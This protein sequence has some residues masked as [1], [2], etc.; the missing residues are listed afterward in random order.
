MCVCVNDPSDQSVSRHSRPCQVQLKEKNLTEAVDELTEMEQLIVSIRQL[1]DDKSADN[2]RLH[3]HVAEL[4]AE[5]VQ[6]QNQVLEL[7]DIVECDKKALVDQKTHGSAAADD[8]AA[9]VLKL[10]STEAE[11]ASVRQSRDLARAGKAQMEH[12]I[13]SEK[14]LI[15]DSRKEFEAW[16]AEMDDK[17]RL[18]D[19]LEQE[20]ERLVTSLE[21]NLA[22]KKKELKLLAA[23]KQAEHRENTQK[24]ASLHKSIEDERKAHADAVQELE[25][26]EAA[27]RSRSRSRLLAVAVVDPT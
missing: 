15:N 2:G 13:V 10:N 17:Q 26:Q 9:L 11:L 22:T 12:E 6:T 4:Q 1:L 27:V 18:R 24:I 14:A 19:Q 16:H 23:E 20:Q 5:L 8:A 25:E 21:E 7:A 3:R